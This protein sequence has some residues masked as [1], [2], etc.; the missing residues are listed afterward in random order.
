MA[1]I[2]TPQ[3][4]TDD[5]SFLTVTELASSVTAW[6][7][8]SESDSDGTWDLDLGADAAADAWAPGASPPR[9][10]A[11]HARAAADVSPL[12]ASP[13][14]RLDHGGARAS[15]PTASPRRPALHIGRVCARAAAASARAR[16]RAL[17]M[18]RADEYLDADGAA[19]AAHAARQ[20]RLDLLRRECASLRLS[21]AL[22]LAS[23]P[24]AVVAD[25]DDLLEQGYAAD[26]V[27]AVVA[28]TRP[29]AAAAARWH[30]EV[31]ADA[32]TPPRS[33]AAHREG[34]L[35]RGLVGLFFGDGTMAGLA[36]CAA[37]CDPTDFPRDMGALRLLASPQFA[38]PREIARLIG[39]FAMTSPLARFA[40]RGRVS[41]DAL[42]R[43]LRP[44]LDGVVGRLKRTKHFGRVVAVARGVDVVLSKAPRP[45]KKLLPEPRRNAP[46]IRRDPRGARWNASSIRRDPRGVARHCLRGARG[47]RCLCVECWNAGGVI[48]K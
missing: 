32:A 47:R 22:V 43:L 42:A 38:L 8:E 40:A 35:A 17:A 10:D 13:P 20:V 26:E 19:G 37:A 29:A 33:G 15:P 41:A 23:A 7:L 6:T 1:S 45:K 30:W 39:A 24:D 46:P 44:H 48:I 5:A 36:R 12:G 18:A 2:A 31:D 27:L 16:D 25:A 9:R 28:A 11:G 21:A 3:S 14:P 4:P 34:T